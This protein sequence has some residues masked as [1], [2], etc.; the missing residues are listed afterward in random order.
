[1]V[2]NFCKENGVFD[3]IIM[4]SVFNVG[5]MVKKVEEYGFYDKIFEIVSVG[6]VWVVDVDGNMLM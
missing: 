5:L 4:G 2:I 3:F 6:I 1:M